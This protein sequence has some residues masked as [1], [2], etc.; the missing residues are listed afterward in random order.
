MPGHGVDHCITHSR[1]I[2]CLPCF[3]FLQRRQANGQSRPETTLVW[4][5]NGQLAPIAE[6]GELGICPGL[7]DI[8][9]DSLVA[10]VEEQL[11]A[12]EA[13]QRKVLGS[14]TERGGFL[15]LR[16]EGSEYKVGGRVEGGWCE[17]AESKLRAQVTGKVFLPKT[18]LPGSVS[19]NEHSNAALVLRQRL[20]LG[21]V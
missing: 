18:P 19:L 10:E 12:T 15:E 20:D 21:V 3:I 17:K 8:S 13:R 14:Q 4:Q 9:I 7:S 11:N 5:P 6:A 1:R 2:A 16:A